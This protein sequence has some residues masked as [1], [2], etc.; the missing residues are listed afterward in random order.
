MSRRAT[1]VHLVAALAL[2]A[3]AWDT[4][5]AQ[6]AT[7]SP[8]P[9]FTRSD[10]SGRR[11][12]LADLRGKLV[13]VAFWASWCEPCRREAPR[14]AAW[15]REYGARGLQII[16]V[17]M[18]DDAATAQRF[19]RH[20]R[21]PYPTVLADGPLGAQFGGVLGL[22]LAI[23][24][25]P[26]GVVLARYR[27]EHQLDRMEAEILKNLPAARSRERDARGDPRNDAAARSTRS[28]APDGSTS[29][30]PR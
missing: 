14:L 19:A 26:D 5:G 21:L 4:R 11:V 2:L 25:G 8:R 20:A 28:R 22:P 6:V 15:Q 30:G 9:D 16:G 12:A 10:L 17:S 7:D 1:I 23:L 29:P 3:A 13:L 27:G 24:M 18:D